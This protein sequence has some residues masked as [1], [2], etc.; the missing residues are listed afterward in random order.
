VS[1]LEQML[2]GTLVG[3]ALL[4]AGWL[5]LQHYGS[6]RY[7]A[8]YT[9]AVA[10]RAQADA[11]AVLFRVRDN[12]ALA[13]RQSESNATITKEKDDEIADLRER[14]AAAGRLRVGAA[15]CPDRPANRANP[16]RPA[17]SNSADTPGGLV[18][19]AADR[20][21][22]QLIADVETDLATGRACQAFLQKNGLVP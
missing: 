21:L 6:K 8:G 20:D 2:V 11:A 7:R 15:V 14:L 5:G 4:V 18:S 17:S 3:L 22:K 1:R 16:E 19:A 12:T 10:E 13:A 9:A